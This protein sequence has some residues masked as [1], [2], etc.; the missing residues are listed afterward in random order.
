[1][2]RQGTPSRPIRAHAR[3]RARARAHAP[4]PTPTPAPTPTPTPT[5]APT[6]DSPELTQCK[7]ILA[8]SW[9]VVKPVIARLGLV[10]DEALE[11]FYIS[12]S[13]YLDACAALSQT[14]RDCLTLADNPVAGLTSCRINEPKQ[15]LRAFDFGD[16]IAAWPS[17]PLPPE[18]SARLSRWLEGTWLMTRDNRDGGQEQ[19]RWVVGRDG[20]VTR[21]EVI[22]RGKV[23]PDALVPATLTF[24][25]TRKLEVHWKGSTTTQ[26]F[27][28]FQADVGVFLASSNGLY[29]AYPVADERHF[30]V[31][32]GSEF[33]LFD[34]GRCEVILGTGLSLPATCTFA[35][36]GDQRTFDTEFQRPGA[37]RPSTTSHVIIGKHFVV[38]SMFESARFVRQK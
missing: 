33:I 16:R 23:D 28:F 25:Q 13:G 2:W 8:K 30:M 18:E 10:P 37:T 1:M 14:H 27:A 20:E 12:D 34:N 5:P 29:D 3:A 9:A 17:E 36:D 35:Q 15:V 32:H 4:T 19:Q 21:A 7:A 6:P 26:S 38:D 31:R 22:R 11:S 24:K